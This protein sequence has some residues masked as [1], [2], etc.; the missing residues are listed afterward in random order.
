MKSW[1]K[2]KPVEQAVHPVPL[3]QLIHPVEHKESFTH[4]LLA[5]R[6]KPPMHYWQATRSAALQTWQP[7]GHGTQ[8]AGVCAYP[9]R[10]REQVT[11]AAVVLD[12]YWL[13]QLATVLVTLDW[14]THELLVEI[15]TYPWAQDEHVSALLLKHEEHGKL[16]LTHVL[17]VML[18]KESGQQLKHMV[19]TELLQVKQLPLQGRQ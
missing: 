8:P 9:W 5:L 15:N 19:G 11:V 17:S 10:Q 6:E 13:A 2:T 16:Q 1:F 4:T 12:A 3:M 7:S 18:M 14:I